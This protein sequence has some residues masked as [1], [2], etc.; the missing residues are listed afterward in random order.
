[1]RTF[2]MKPNQRV[3]IEVVG[4]DPPE[5]YPSR[6]ENVGRDHLSLAA[7]FGQVGAVPLHVGT[8]LRVTL[9]HNGGAHAFDTAVVGRQAEPLP[10]LLVERPTRLEV[11]QRRQYFRQ[12][13]VVR[14]LCRADP[15]SPQE[16]EGLTRSLGGG[17]I[18]M[19]SHDIAGCQWILDHAATGEPVWLEVE[20]PDRPLNVLATVV[21][22]RLD[23]DEGYI[24]MAFEFTDLP[25]CE[26]ERLIRYLFVLQRDALRKGC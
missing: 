3:S 7:P 22:T 4:S 12:A 8:K 25:D 24:E 11:L 1:M 18:S 17:G 26:R 13:A 9:F 2:T 15:D 14:S 23:R 21:W 20:L 6:V 5:R 16:I 19:R 10:L